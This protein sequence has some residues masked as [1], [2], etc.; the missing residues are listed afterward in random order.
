M[1]DAV[2]GHGDEALAKCIGTKPVDVLAKQA[3]RGQRS[4]AVE[5]KRRGRGSILTRH[6]RFAEVIDKKEARIE[7]LEHSI[8]DVGPLRHGDLL[9]GAKFPV[10][11]IDSPKEIFR[12]RNHWW[13]PTS[14]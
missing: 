13:P 9:D 4:G 11:R 14:I 1:D 7:R 2:P 12:L 6:C 3:A 5:T 8:G 10:G